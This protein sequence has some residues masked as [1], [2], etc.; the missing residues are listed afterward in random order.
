M[1]V[2][3]LPPCH[4]KLHYTEQSHLRLII[5]LIVVTVLFRLIM[6][7]SHSKA[8][9]KGMCKDIGNKTGEVSVVLSREDVK[10]SPNS[11]ISMPS[12]TVN[13][14]LLLDTL[15]QSNICWK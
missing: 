13:Y 1:M 7:S 10:H 4:L 12:V 8:D 2:K 14:S 15:M 6:F 11:S 3:L 5:L 9:M